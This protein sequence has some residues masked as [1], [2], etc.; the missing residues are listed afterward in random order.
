L[1][2]YA[3]VQVVLEH[4]VGAEVPA[5]LERAERVE[6]LRGQRARPA[7]DQTRDLHRDRRRARHDPSRAQVGPDRAHDGERVHARVPA[8]PAV[9]RRDDGLA[10]LRGDLVQRH[11]HPPDAVGRQEQAQ[12][13]AIARAHDGGRGRLQALEGEWKDGIRE[14]EQRHSEQRGRASGQRESR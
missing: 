6:Q 9:L 7:L 3:Q 4:L 10:Q 1:P 5:E 2:K 8:Q 14:R 13:R 11:G 12:R